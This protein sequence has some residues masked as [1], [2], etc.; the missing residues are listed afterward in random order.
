MTNKTLRV[1]QSDK[2]IADIATRFESCFR[3]QLRPIRQ[4]GR[5]AEFPLITADG[6][7][8]DVSQLWGPLLAEPGF[9]PIYNNPQAQDLI[10][11]VER[12]D[13]NIAVEVGRGT[14]ELSI[15]PRE[16]LW[17]LQEAYNQAIALVARVAESRGIFLL[18]FGIQ[19]RTP[20][21][22]PLMTPRPRYAALHK[23]VGAPWLK[24][25][26]TAADQT[27]VDICRAELLDAINWMNLLSAPLIALCANSSV[28]VGR[29]GKFLSGREGKLGELGE[30]RYG[31]TPRKFISIEEFIRY[32]CAYQCFVLPDGDGFKQI[33]LPFTQLLPYSQTLFDDFL[34]HEHYVWNSARARVAQSTIEVRPACQQPP[35][36]PFAANALI[37]GWVESLPQVAAYFTNTLGDA[38]WQSMLM[39]RRQV[40]RDGLRAKEPAPNLI[41]E[42]VKI[43]EAGL[44]RR[45][46]GEEKFL[47]PVWNRI[48]RRESPGLRAR[49]IF[50][51]KGMDALI[52]TW[53]V[54]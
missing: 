35:D 10:Y 39:Y 41:D 21:T 33:Q 23:A 28:Y 37:L 53:K 25:T 49:K 20:P 1:A 52:K 44:R 48:E 45:G 14:I 16:D 9:K 7:A 19:P 15:G 5:E 4:V 51:R 31:M 54:S 13:L 32:L 46:R 17:Q 8:G 47:A 3:E 43:A 34:F 12:G 36:E 6:R 42:L 24:L 30:L 29:P 40:V 11:A 50:E 27:H 18:G 26:T 2:L 22:L 38:A